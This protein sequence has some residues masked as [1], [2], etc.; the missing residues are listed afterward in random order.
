MIKPE[1]KID[2]RVEGI[3]NFIKA[4][5]FCVPN[6]QRP[7]SWE[8]EKH[9]IDLFTDIENNMSESEY[10]LGTIVLTQKQDNLLEIVDGQQRLT[11]ILLFMAAIRDVFMEKNKNKKIQESYLSDYDRREDKEVPKLTLSNQDNDFYREYV[12]NKEAN[13]NTKTKSNVAI[14]ESYLLLFSKLKEYDEQVLLDFMDFIDTKLKIVI[15]IVSE[16]TNAFTIFETLNDRGLALAQIDLLKNYLYSKCSNSTILKNV[17]QNWNKLSD[18]F[19]SNKLFLI[20]YIKVFWMSN[21]GFIREKDNQ[22]FKAIKDKISTNEVQNFVLQ[23]LNESDYYFA[24]QNESHCFWR[25]NNLYNCSKYIG[26]LNQ[27]ELTQY[28]PL[29]FSIIKNFENTIEKEKSIKLLLSWMVRMLIVGS[30]KGGTIE[31]SYSKNAIKIHKNE[32]TTAKQ[33]RDSLKLLIPD[34]DTFKDAFKAATI[35]KEKLARFYLREIE[36]HLN[37]KNNEQE[38]ITDTEKVNLEHILPKKMD[39]NYPT[40]SEEL[41]NQYVKRIG[42]LTLMNSKANRM[43][44]SSNFQDK[45]KEYSKSNLQITKQIAQYADWNIESINDRQSYLADIAVKVWTIKFDEHD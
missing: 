19:D 27:L 3:G 30:N 9:T 45:K 2:F 37:S 42:N 22:I 38:V 1:S 6:F 26:L 14:K 16:E 31:Q 4:N 29:L 41:H 7:Y 13:C 33:L 32:I 36:N 12:V 10:F 15:I 23:L 28:Y 40:F 20:D 5:K 11:T 8:S 18:R 34:D 24:I 39:S 43:K 21:Y 44:G 17:Q 25:E 35:S